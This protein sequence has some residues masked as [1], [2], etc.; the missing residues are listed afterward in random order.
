MRFIRKH[1]K[2]ITIITLTILILA[3]IVLKIYL[4]NNSINKKQ[5]V[6][7]TMNDT[8]LIKEE[9]LTE[10]EEETRKVY[11]DIKGAITNP[12]VYEVDKTKKVIDVINLAGGL[13]SEADTSMINLAKQVKDEMVVIIYTKKEVEEAKIKSP[14]R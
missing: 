3:L 8:N 13:T 9:T 6:V 7:A 11:V 12:G 10:V 2:I 4:K 14:A 1:I 5:E